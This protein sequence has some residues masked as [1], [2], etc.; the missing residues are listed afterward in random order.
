VGVVPG[1]VTSAA[2]AGCHRRIREG[3]VTL[4]TN[5]D[6]MAQLIAPA[7]TPSLQRPEKSST[8]A[9]PQCHTLL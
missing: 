5:H 2:S 7:E 3:F 8:P 9:T 1:P 6:E 4:V